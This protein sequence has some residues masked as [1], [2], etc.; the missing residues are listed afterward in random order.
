MR[1]IVLKQ[2]LFFAFLIVVPDYGICQSAT[3][4][5]KIIDQKTKQP[6]TGV[7]VLNLSNQKNATYTDDEGIFHLLV[8]KND[9]LKI[10]CVG[11]KDSVIKN[12]ETLNLSS[13][14][15]R[16]NFFLLDEVVINSISKGSSYSLGNTG[17]KDQY[18]YQGGTKGSVLLVFVP[19]VDSN[20]NKFITKLKY[21]LMTIERKKHDY[22]SENEKINKGV[23]RVRLYSSKDTSIFPK[24]ELLP[25]NIIQTIPLKDEQT[26]IVDISKYKINFPAN[27][28]FVGLEWLGEKN[29]SYEINLNPAFKTIK[30]K[31]DPFSFISFYGKE[32]NNSGRILNLYHSPMFGIEIEE[33]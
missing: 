1:Y 16:A 24:S 33:Y 31:I 15:L 26:L 19:N 8:T 3:L 4:T 23:V 7:I 29:N 6:I 25:E 9:S 22:K 27:G 11:Y 2:I 10:I 32:F 21:E 12:S 14:E 17:K 18:S 5:A 30:S 13:I 28:V 20:T